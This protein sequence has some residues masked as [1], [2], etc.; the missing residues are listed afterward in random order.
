MTSYVL[1]AHRVLL[2]AIAMMVIVVSVE[3]S[4]EFQVNFAVPWVPPSQRGLTELQ[5]IRAH[6]GYD[7]LKVIT[8]VRNASAY[9]WALAYVGGLVFFGDL[10]YLLANQTDYYL[11]NNSDLQVRSSYIGSI[12]RL[13]TYGVLRD[14]DSGK[15]TILVPFDLYNPDVL[16]MQALAPAGVNVLQARQLDPVAKRNLLGAWNLAISTGNFVR[17]LSSYVA[18]NSMAE[19]AA[20]PGWVSTTLET[21]VRVAQNFT[22]ESRCSLHIVTTVRAGETVYVVLNGTWNLAT[23]SYIGFYLKGTTSSRGNYQLNLL[24]NSDQGYVSYYIQTFT[25]VSLWDGNVHGIVRELSRFQTQG[26]PD[27]SS[28]H[29]TEFG[30][31]SANDG[32]FDYALQYLITAHGTS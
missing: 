1:T 20:Y 4:G 27:L 31:Y 25:D 22:N 23:E 12:Q 28:I 16:E 3:F 26:S 5:W 6:F 8:V 13:W 30:I 7:N 17:P 21:T 14:I 24:L 11:L 29:S 32:V 10:L 18:V 9:L 2:V 19:C 15:Y